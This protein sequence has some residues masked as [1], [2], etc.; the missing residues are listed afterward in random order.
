MSPQC[1]LHRAEQ[2][3]STTDLYMVILSHL[4][5]FPSLFS[6]PNLV[7]SFLRLVWVRLLI[8]WVLMS[9]KLRSE[10]F[11]LMVLHQS[12]MPRHL[13]LFGVSWDPLGKFLLHSTFSCSPLGSYCLQ[14]SVLTQGASYNF[15]L[16]VRA[17]A[18]SSPVSQRSVSTK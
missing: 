1:L 7:L 9:T 8:M 16:L 6:S 12:S 2:L 14:G 17:A 5:H 10:V 13:W 18:T 11:L 3:S 15:I 4:F